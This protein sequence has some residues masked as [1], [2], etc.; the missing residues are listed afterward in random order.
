MKGKLIRVLIVFALAYLATM[1]IPYDAWTSTR[2]LQFLAFD[3]PHLGFE[4]YVSQGS[5]YLTVLITLLYVIVPIVW[6][7]A[8]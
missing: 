3:I 8:K 6:R 7:K 1:A 2:L 4:N 5:F